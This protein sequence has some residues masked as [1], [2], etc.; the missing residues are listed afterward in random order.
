MNR[1]PGEHVVAA[2]AALSAS[3]VAGPLPAQ[4]VGDPLP[5]VV[6]VL[7]I[8]DRVRVSVD[9]VRIVGEVAGATLEGFE[10]V[11]GG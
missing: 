11:Q 2:L 5:S 7:G 8:S 6:P 1:A 9:G 4:D 10:F 3:T